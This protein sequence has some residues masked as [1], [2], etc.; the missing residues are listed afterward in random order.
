MSFASDQIDLLKTAYAAVLQGQRVRY[1][2]RDLTRAD[3]RWISEEL[4]KW[5]RRAHAEAVQA[6]GGSPGVRIATF[7][8]HAP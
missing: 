3:A 8:R 1:G 2:E 4:D 7:N 5:L 6:G